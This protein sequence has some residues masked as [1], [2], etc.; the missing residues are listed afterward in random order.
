MLEIDELVQD[1]L[2]RAIQ[3]LEDEDPLAAQ[4]VIDRDE[5]VNALD[6]KADDETVIGLPE[7]RI[8]EVAESIS[9]DLL[10]LGG[11]GRSTLS[12][13]LKGSVAEDV[14]R[15]SRIPVHVVTQTRETVKH[16]R[17]WE[18]RGMRSILQFLTCAR[19]VPVYCIVQVGVFRVRHGK[20]QSAANGHQPG[21]EVQRLEDDVHGCTN[22]ASAGCAGAVTWVVPSR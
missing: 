18:F 13:L 17:S 22:A 21:D 1:Q 9:P 14:V 19:R 7:N 15:K 4:E 20:A 5:K 16:C 3:T 10:V 6:V 11:N 12:K 8:L 2:K